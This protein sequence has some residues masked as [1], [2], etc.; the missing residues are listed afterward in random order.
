[1][2]DIQRHQ[3]ANQSY[4][5]E[6]VQLRELARSTQHMFERQDAQQKRRL[7]NFEVSNCSWKQRGELT[8]TLCQ[9]FDIRANAAVIW[10]CRWGWQRRRNREI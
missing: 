3:T 4:L 9:A 1:L 10:R 5:E 7:L 8:V 2:R 6:G